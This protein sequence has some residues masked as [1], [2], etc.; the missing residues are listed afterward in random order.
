MDREMV[1]YILFYDPK[2]ERFGFKTK[3]CFGGIMELYVK[4]EFRRR[5]FATQ[6]IQRCVEYLKSK[7]TIDVRVD[8][9]MHNK[10]AVNLYWKHGIRDWMT[11]LKKSSTNTRW[12]VIDQPCILRNTAKNSY[13][14]WWTEK[15]RNSFEITACGEF[16]TRH[17][18]THANA[19]PFRLE[20]SALSNQQNSAKGCR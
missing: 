9:L 3:H 1:G 15:N 14:F 5:G 16:K 10:N 12:C 11:I 17:F 7:G 2:N 19:A 18:L 4:P 8:V 20:W 13:S 6:L